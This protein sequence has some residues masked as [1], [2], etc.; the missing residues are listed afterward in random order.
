MNHSI[1]SHPISVFVNT[2]MN[3]RVT[4]NDGYFMTVS[5]IICFSEM[6]LHNRVS[7]DSLILQ[8]PVNWAFCEIA[9]EFDSFSLC[10]GRLEYLHHSPVSHRRQQKGN[11]VPGGITWPPCHWGT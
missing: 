1:L 8:R 7:L 4:L 2:A 10:E 9:S 3:I 5:V 6:A 11:L